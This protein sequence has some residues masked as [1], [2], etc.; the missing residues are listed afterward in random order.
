LAKKEEF[1]IETKLKIAGVEATGNLDGGTLKFNVDTSAFK[2]L[3]TDA[4]KTAAQVKKKLDSIK[5]NK[6]KIELNQNSLRT[7]ESQIRK[8]ITNAVKKVSV[9]V[10]ANVTGGKGKAGAKTGK[11]EKHLDAFANY[12]KEA[13][14]SARSF[15]KT[16]QRLVDVAKSMPKDAIAGGTAAA[17]AGDGGSVPMPGGGGL[18]MPQGAGAGQSVD[19]Q[20]KAATNAEKARIAL[21]ETK[22]KARET[23]DALQNAFNVPGL[24]QK[25][26]GQLKDFREQ[27]AQINSLRDPRNAKQAGVARG[28]VQETIKTFN[29]LREAQGKAPLED[30]K[31]IE[32]LRK[33]SNAESK[34]EAT[35]RKK[36]ADQD[37]KAANAA[38][39]LAA[40]RRKSVQAAQK[41]LDT[42]MR[43]RGA[44][45]GGGGLRGGGGGGGAGASG[46][47]GGAD[48]KGQAQDANSLSAGIGKATEQL[49]K[50]RFAGTVFNE[51]S[52]AIRGA[53]KFVLD[54]NDAVLE[55]N[56]ILRQNGADL[57]RTRGQLLDLS[58]KT[59]VA[60]GEVAELAQAFAR[61]GL[62]GRGFGSVVELTDTAL[63]GFQGTTLSAE[64]ASALMIQTIGQISSGMSQ[65]DKSLVKTGRLFDILGK[66]E[67]ITASKASDVATALRRS[68]ASLFATGADIEEVTGIISVLQET[69]QRGGEVIGTAL[70]TVASRVS[71]SSSDAAKALRNI[72][73]STIDTNG[74]L[75]NIF[76]ILG[77]VAGRFENLSEAEQANTLV[78]VAGVRQVE[79]LRSALNSFGRIQD[80]VTQAREADGDAARK[81]SVEQQKFSNLIEKI[82]AQFNKFAVAMGGSFAGIGN[83]FKGTLIVVNNLLDGL[84][85]V[86]Q[87]F[88][89]MV[90]TGASLAATIGAVWFAIK[91]IAAASGVFKQILGFL[92]GSSKA[93]KDLGAATQMVSQSV[94]VGMNKSFAST[95][96]IIDRMDQEM[97]QFAATTQMATMK[98]EQLAVARKQAMAEMG[99]GASS[100]AVDFRSQEILREKQSELARESLAGREARSRA[101]DRATSKQGFSGGPS[102]VLLERQKRGVIT[103][104]K[105]LTKFQK[106]LQGAGKGLKSFGN[107]LSSMAPFLMAGAGLGLR[108]S[109]LSDRSDSSLALDAGKGIAGSAA[110]GAG[111]GSMFGLIGTAAGTAVGALVGVY[112]QFSLIGE[113]SAKSVNTIADLARYYELAS[114]N[115]ANYTEALNKQLQG[116]LKN[117]EVLRAKEGTEEQTRGPQSIEAINQQEVAKN[118]LSGVNK[119]LESTLL[120]GLDLTQAT[121]GD[122]GS[123]TAGVIDFNQLDTIAS[124][125]NQFVAD[126]KDLTA[127]QRGDVRSEIEDILNRALQERMSGDQFVQDKA[128]GRALNALTVSIPGLVQA[129]RDSAAEEA[130]AASRQRQADQQR[131]G[132]RDLGSQ[133]ADP[134]GAA[135]SKLADSANRFGANLQTFANTIT[136][137]IMSLNKSVL[138]ATTPQQ[139][140]AQAMAKLEQQD[141]ANTIQLTGSENKVLI[142]KF[143]QKIEDITSSPEFQG[144]AGETVGQLQ[145]KITAGLLGAIKKSRE[146]GASSA[147]DINK[148]LKETAAEI[149][150]I[151]GRILQET[152]DEIFKE[153]TALGE[154]IL[155]NEETISKQ[156]IAVNKALVTALSQTLQE[157]AR[158]IQINKQRR[159]IAR[160][161]AE[162][163]IQLLT[164]SRQLIAQRKIEV[165]FTNQNIAALREQ[166]SSLDDRIQ[167]EKEVLAQ[168]AKNV[169]AKDKLFILE[170]KRTDI[171]IALES[172]LANARLASA[173]ATIQLSKAALQ[174]T[175]DFASFQKTFVEGVNGIVDVL[176]IG[177]TPIE[178]FNAKLSANSQSFR[179]SQ[180]ELA[181][182]VQVVNSTITDQAERTQALTDIQRR[183]AQV[184]LDAAK[185]EAD[186]IAQR[187][188]A[189]KQITGELLQNQDAQAQA[190]G[191][192]IEATKGVSAAF[193]A[194][195]DAANGSILATT[196]YN[197]NLKLTETAN[198]KLLG[199]LNG[200][201]QEIDAVSSI[202]RQAESTARQMGSSERTLLEIRRDSINQQLQLFNNL[203]SEQSSLARQFFQGSAQDQADLFLGLQEA[204]GVAE[205]LGGSFDSFKKMGESAIN[206]L[207]SQLLALPQESRQRI[208]QSLETLKTVGGSVG[209]F[210]AQELLTAIETASLGVSGEGLNVDP[211]F[212]VQQRIADLSEQQARLATDD[213]INAQEGVRTAKEA[214]EQAKAQK[215]LAEIQLERI[216]EEGTQLRSKL[217][218]LQ[219][220]LKSSILRGTEVQKNG[221][222]NVAGAINRMSNQVLTRLPEAFSM[223]VAQEF[224]NNMSAVGLGGTMPTQMSP[225]AQQAQALRQAGN[226]VAQNIQGQRAAAS[227][228][229]T[230]STTADSAQRDQNNL[231]GGAGTEQTNKILDTIKQDIKD[232]LTAQNEANTA[233]TSIDTNTGTGSTGGTAA[234]QLTPIPDINVNIAG[235]QQIQVTGFEAGV[236]QI[237]AGLVET[238]GGFVTDT[239][240]TN[241]AN[242]VV[243]S[244]RLQLE[245]LGILNRNQL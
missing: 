26:Q 203:L 57:D 85:K 211:L 10:G 195:R 130:L 228:L 166:V 98:A 161:N 56:K 175:K 4:T 138:Q 81:Q 12:I 159:D 233:L 80:V 236:Q 221:F 62:D 229:S 109:S 222:N 47:A 90:S 41:E 124:A 157:E 72:G 241:I 119:K 11:A 163:Q 14:K 125:F 136:K 111:I 40:S 181:A 190:Q 134:F 122:I 169:A 105:G 115:A 30:S 142:D 174:Q 145:Q 220:E 207:G 51:V 167:A 108:E 179:I 28:Q 192:I 66:A 75:R 231:P 34:R 132:V 8:A 217:G 3:V 153:I 37:A 206:D 126:Q 156:R 210:G 22:Q 89:G 128:F 19:L 230:I 226:N 73:V 237:V 127:D 100:S 131:R 214:L 113:I 165:E 155:K 135:S 188:E 189:V 239:E 84:N 23:Q 149:P 170:Q 198:Q 24:T 129:I 245:R 197:I 240:A 5:L 121:L 117:I 204:G 63:R 162:S 44:M 151:G 15:A 103:S 140:L 232:L 79:I 227:Q 168:D 49:I 158:V 112:E 213:L 118:F 25:L 171:S 64:Q 234:A 39:R 209:G 67:D 31:A 205:L 178:E 216:R 110:M 45:G 82:S 224:R 187:R 101:F 18:P 106:T 27:L 29:Q 235:Q 2:K 123:A 86:D 176:A 43:R 185:A 95:A 201:R 215:D 20:N 152:Q 13:N 196:R 6:I 48:F 65:L 92:T 7:V 70:K 184:T 177:R 146:T 218:N 202:F 88:G 223:A 99:P 42:L 200:T 74:E 182:E 186:I 172:Q 38:D 87:F 243:E 16:M 83:L 55:L 225:G 143:R 150:T 94:T 76:D 53:T 242:Q 139:E 52:S 199:S 9:D 58:V 107:G 1:S 120:E 91:G 194:Y 244:I 137:S 141:L 71:N 93:A 180:A 17:K 160:I 193:Q 59:G 191:A 33:M 46:G 147:G 148:I 50:Y 173:R 54:F 104:A 212:E 208:I 154:G 69:T 36:V 219:G 144:D 61:A 21:E 32:Q 97:K 164:G 96:T 133:L 238:F 114:N 60:G 183:S 77:D 68:A 78:S 102:S 116:E 35:F